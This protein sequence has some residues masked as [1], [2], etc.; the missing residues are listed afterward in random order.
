MTTLKRLYL[1]K[2]RINLNENTFHGLENIEIID[3]SFNLLTKIKSNSF[4]N[5][6]KLKTLYL[7]GNP[8]H[9]I[10]SNGFR[11]LDVIEILCLHGNRF[12]EMEGLKL[13]TFQHLS[14]LKSLSLCTSQT[15]Y[16]DSSMYVG[17]ENLEQINFKI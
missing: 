12:R 4:H 2:N 3:F 8:I 6:N 14:S 13:N 9:S 7:S 15:N 11:G 5:L 16:F 1:S 17:L 10:E